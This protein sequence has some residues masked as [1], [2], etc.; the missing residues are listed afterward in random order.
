MEY[1]VF[2]KECAPAYME[3]LHIYFS[4]IKAYL[5]SKFANRLTIRWFIFN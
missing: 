5:I 4:K 3:I 1:T 2:Q